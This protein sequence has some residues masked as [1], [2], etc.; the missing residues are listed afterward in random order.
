[1]AAIEQAAASPHAV[2]LSVTEKVVIFD[3][4]CILKSYSCLVFGFRD[5]VRL[6]MTREVIVYISDWVNV[7]YA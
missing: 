2:R 3:A 6:R 4:R 5:L 7:T 1:M